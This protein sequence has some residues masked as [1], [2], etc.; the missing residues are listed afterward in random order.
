[1]E[2]KPPRIDSQIAIDAATSSVAI[3]RIAKS[4]DRRPRSDHRLAGAEVDPDTCVGHIQGTLEPS[5]VGVSV[6]PNRRISAN[7]VSNTR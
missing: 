1:V 5:C 4:L 6:M 2:G 3:P 7:L